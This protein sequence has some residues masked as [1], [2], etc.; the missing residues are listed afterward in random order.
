M[1]E[2]PSIS[3]IFND[4][5]TEQR[6]IIEKMD[7]AIFISVPFKR[8]PNDLLCC[9]TTVAAERLILGLVWKFGKPSK[10]K[11]PMGFCARS[12]W[13]EDHYHLSKNTISRAY[14][15]LK[16]KGYIQKTGD[17]LIT[18]QSTAPR[19][20]T[21]GSPRNLKSTARLSTWASVKQ[22]S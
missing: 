12:K 11:R 6:K 10:N 9:V 8:K 14:T 15:S 3:D 5:V 1:S 19:S 2:L 18:L 4:D 16:D 13:I 22:P 17:G 21:L 20:K 7:K